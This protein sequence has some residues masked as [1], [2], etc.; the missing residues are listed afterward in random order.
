MSTCSSDGIPTR[1][2]PPW[3]GDEVIER[4]RLLHL[5]SRPD[6]R[7]AV[8]AA[9]PGSGKTVFATQWVANGPA[10]CAWLSLDPTDDHPEQFWHD[11]V[12]SLDHARPAAF[13]GAERVATAGRHGPEAVAAALAADASR[14]DRPLG[15]V[16]D[17][18]DAVRDPAV[19]GSLAALVEAL[20]PQLRLVCVTRRDP[21][22]PVGRWRARRWLV[23]VRQRDLCCDLDET[24][25]L[26]AALGED[27]LGDDDL[28]TLHAKTEG[29]IAALNVAAVAMR[30][31]P[32]GEA[33]AELTGRHALIA[34]L[35]CNE[36]VDRQPDDVRE[37]M[38]RTSIADHL[39]AEFCDVLTGRGDSLD[40]LRALEADTHLLAAVDDERTTFRYH[41]LLGE[42]LRSELAHRSPDLADELHRIAAD[43]FETRGDIGS[44]V[45]HLL[46]GGDRDRAFELVVGSAY[47]DFDRGDTA[48]ARTWLDAFPA[49]FVTS[50]IARVI[51]YTQ[52]LSTYAGPEERVVWT[53][54]C[55]VALESAGEPD[56][57]D[58]ARV[59]ALR[60]VQFVIDATGDDGVECGTR[61]S[62]AV[63]RGIDIGSL[64]QRVQP[65]LAGA[66]LLAG[67]PEAAED[68][69]TRH[70]GGGELS[71]MVL[72]PAISARVALRRGSL[73]RAAERSA[74][75]LAAA[76][77]M[78]M[79]THQ[80]TLD[81][82]IAKL[83]V[84]TERNELA[85]TDE[86][87]GDLRELCERHESAA[88]AVLARLDEIRVA[89]A[90]GGVD[91]ALALIDEIRARH[92]ERER[93]HLQHHVDVL[94]ARLRI[95][96][97]QTD[98]GESLLARLP[99]DHADRPLL[100]ARLHV[101][102]GETRD[103]RAT[104]RFAHLSNRRDRLGAELLLVRLAVL[105][106]TDPAQHLDRVVELAA[107]EGFVRSVL[108]E[109]ATIARLVRRAADA[110]A[111]ADAE[112]LARSLGGPP[113]RRHRY[114]DTIVK[115]SR[116]EADVLRFLP[117]RLTNHEIASECFVSVNTVKVHLRSIY[118]KLGVS[119]RS[120]AI[121]LARAIGAL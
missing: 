90:R 115:F 63:E 68:V 100:Q 58:R 71:D 83:G 1:F 92:D 47:D 38:I 69:L 46:A 64:S 54:R 82:R 78:A 112:A 32:P 98:V 42:L 67:D 93:P 62:T 88:Y 10:D 118:A 37:L 24:T 18:L 43:C 17:D 16:L 89:A 30:G 51:G 27:R 99:P 65:A 72:V 40:R 85:A 48:L 56:P 35:L 11:V 87:A 23:E 96:A 14:L 81:A 44:A 41:P 36:V 109:G 114:D 66:H 116:R 34:E 12:R 57:A 80:G 104:L 4:P 45:H 28:R 50:D 121:E 97:G 9:S 60:L 77:S 111:T 26:L 33:V 49:D 25:A 73:H 53:T 117:S 119:S 110:S 91:A 95:D 2:R 61:A 105:E 8:V 20:P 5:L 113:R 15:L 94:E 55:R 86:V 52:A 6:W 102:R 106:G 74:F 108:E 79:P 3:I 107:P 29:W 76:R 101:A 103:G 120:E 22:L 19:L 59:D 21:A 70:P 31:K 13:A 39:D 75:A 84:L 7:I